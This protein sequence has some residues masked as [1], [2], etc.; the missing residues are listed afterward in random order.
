MLNRNNR[1]MF[2]G[3]AEKITFYKGSYWIADL[4]YFSGL[5]LKFMIIVYM[6]NYFN[7]SVFYF[8]AFG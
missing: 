2:S 8:L 7:N 3:R 4:N 5:I 1:K 6:N